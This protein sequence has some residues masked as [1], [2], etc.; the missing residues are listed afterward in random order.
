MTARLITD[1][2]IAV[3]IGIIYNLTIQKSCEIFNN[4]MNYKDRVQ[5]NLLISFG[6]GITGLLLATLFFGDGSKY[7]NRSIRYGLYLGSVLLLIHSIIYNWGTLENDSKLIIMIL[8]LAVLIWYTY[9]NMVPEEKNSKKKYI[10]NSEDSDDLSYGG[11]YLPATYIENIEEYNN[12]DD[13]YKI[14]NF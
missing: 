13:E 8:T 9:Y 12:I 14:I 2:V 7:K 1:I 11:Q 4:N 10:D 3:P 5:K 6:G